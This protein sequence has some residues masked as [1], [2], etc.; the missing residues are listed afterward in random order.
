LKNAFLGGTI[1]GFIELAQL[2]MIKWQKKQELEQYNEMIN[3][4]V[5][6]EKLRRQGEM[7]KYREGINSPIPQFFIY[8]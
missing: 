5:S 6:K 4:E 3:N 7:D 1:L 2:I 8:T